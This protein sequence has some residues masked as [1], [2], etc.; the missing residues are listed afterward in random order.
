V[1]KISLGK[2][3][4]YQIETA[5]FDFFREQKL[6]EVV[7]KGAIV[8]YTAIVARTRRKKSV[9]NLIR[10]QRLKLVFETLAHR[11][12]KQI[13]VVRVGEIAHTVRLATY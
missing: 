11:V 1:H 6:D 8:S 10:V 3:A 9:T 7:Q 2:I 4:V 13:A 5:R 12:N